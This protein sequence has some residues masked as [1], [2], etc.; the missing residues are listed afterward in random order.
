MNH[1]RNQSC[2]VVFYQL[3]YLLNYLW[4]SFSFLSFHFIDLC[5]HLGVFLFLSATNSTLAAANR[6][7][8]VCIES[9][10]RR[11]IHGRWMENPWSLRYWLMRSIHLR[12]WAFPALNSVTTASKLIISSHS[13]ALMLYPESKSYVRKI[14]K[15]QFSVANSLSLLCWFYV[16]NLQISFAL[17]QV[18]TAFL[19]QIWVSHS[20]VSLIQPH[21]I[22]NFIFW[23]TNSSDPKPI[24]NFE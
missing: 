16:S 6:S 2:P 14:L 18:N 9:F 19:A 7:F 24:S 11:M 22:S 13:K 1:G 21:L 4:R 3:N 10:W 5:F 15:L 23:N 12:L 17:K 8:S 20:L